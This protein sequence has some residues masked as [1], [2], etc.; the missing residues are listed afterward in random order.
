MRSRVCAI[1]S[2]KLSVVSVGVDCF[3][4]VRRVRVSHTGEEVFNFGVVGNSLEI[5]GSIE[6]GV[7]ICIVGKGAKLAGDGTGD[8]GG[9]GGLF[10]MFLTGSNECF[11]QGLFFNDSGPG[12][13]F[14]VSGIVR[15]QYPI[16]GDIFSSF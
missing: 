1:A 11:V 13:V 7:A 5:N 10:E 2:L 6:D 8:E 16:E 3:G 12:G 9:V 4:G 15:G 14:Q